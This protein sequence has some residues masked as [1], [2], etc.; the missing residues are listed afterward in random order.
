MKELKKETGVVGIFQGFTKD[1]LQL[2]ASKEVK[3]EQSQLQGK[4]EED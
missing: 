4:T 2:A 3:N 1:E